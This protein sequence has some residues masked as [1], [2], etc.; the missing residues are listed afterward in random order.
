MAIIKRITEELTFLQLR[1]DPQLLKSFE[2]WFKE[3]TEETETT[4]ERSISAEAT[5]EDGF[6]IPFISKLLTKLMG[7]IKGSDKQ[8]M[9]IRNK[10]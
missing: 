5:T 8:R 2:L 9:I 1:F 3:V 4:V 7:K 10:L 6:E